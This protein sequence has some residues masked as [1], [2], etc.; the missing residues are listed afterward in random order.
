MIKTTYNCD[1]CGQEHDRNDM[2]GFSITSTGKI[3]AVSRDTFYNPIKVD[4]CRDCLEKAGFQFKENEPAVQNTKNV[5]DLLLDVL[6]RLG[7]QFEG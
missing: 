6:Y 7:V 1:I 4:I 5:E 2:A 3:R